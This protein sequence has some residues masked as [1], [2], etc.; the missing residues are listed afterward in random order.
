M[1]DDKLVALVQKSWKLSLDI[2]DCAEACIKQ[3]LVPEEHRII[4]ESV[5][6]AAYA[7]YDCTY[8]NLCERLL[9]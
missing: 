9:S 1:K 2:S 5:I 8:Q 7:E 4:L 3:A 6:R